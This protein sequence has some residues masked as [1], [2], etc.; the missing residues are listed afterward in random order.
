[1]RLLLVAL[2]ALSLAG[3]VTDQELDHQACSNYGFKPGTNDYAQCRM[4]RDQNRQAAIMQWSAQQQQ[5]QQQFYSQ[6]Q[7]LLLRPTV[8]TN[9]NQWTPGQIT[10]TTR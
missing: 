9:C 4:S 6:Q 2:G 8:T 5:Q 10:C 7:Q 3:C 1:M